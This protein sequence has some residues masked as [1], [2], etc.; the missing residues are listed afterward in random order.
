MTAATAFLR[1]ILRAP[2]V[3]APRVMNVDENPAYPGAFNTVKEEGLVPKRS[4]PRQCRYLN[5]VVE[6]DH[7][8]I[9]RRT[10]PMLGFK[11]FRS[12]WR[13]LRGI[14]IMSALRKDQ[15]RWIV[16]GDVVAHT[17]LIH[18]VFGLAT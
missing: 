8:F 3:A 14:E 1:K 2:H 18:R 9:K 15:A 4:R 13:T 6:Q 7:H 16:K 5:N 11:R 10:R 12:A 17:R